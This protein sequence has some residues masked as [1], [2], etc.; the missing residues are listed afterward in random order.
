M[1]KYIYLCL[2]ALTGLTTSCKK[3]KS[4]DAVPAA[5]VGMVEDSVY[6]FAQE[7]YL[8]YDALP[9]ISVFNPTSYTGSNDITALTNEVN[10]ISQLKINPLTNKPYEYDTDPND[11]PGQAKYSFIDNGQVAQELSGSNGDFG[12][13][14]IYGVSSTD[15]RVKYVNPGSP[16]AKAGMHRG[17]LITSIVNVPGI[18]GT[19]ATNINAI[20][21]A[22]NA[23]T[24]GMTLKRNN[25]TT[26]SVTLSVANY[27][28][29]PVMKDSV[30]TTSNS[31]KVGYLVFSTFTALT[32]AQPQLDAAF[33][34]FI[35]QGV[36]DLVVDL[37]YNGG[38]VVE[39]AEY[40]DNLIVPAANT[41]TNMYTAYYNNKL[42]NDQYPLLSTKYLINKG[43][44]STAAN[45]VVF[46]KQKTLSINNVIFIVTGGTASAS[47]L[48]INNLRPHM[49]VQLLGTTTYGKPVGFFAIPIGTYQLYIPEFS[50]LNSASQGGYYT[51]M[52]PGSAD[53]PGYVAADDV[54][55]D[56]GDPT[57]GLLAH[58]LSYVS[59]GTYAIPQQQVQSVS[60]L[61]SLAAQQQS[62]NGKLNDHKFNGMVYGNKLKRRTR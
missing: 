57:E 24:I 38:G 16:A 10:A 37:R 18:D 17:D 56:F 47:E 19:S 60:G 32:N 12:F 58:A 22:L 54:S 48:T 52:V 6:L 8:W 45:T 35:A 49:N 61:N 13:F 11:P 50:T 46:S 20:N 55:K 36:T 23:T 15:L 14:P 1:K 44:F 7:D 41:G 59:V 30:Y 42:Q 39:T 51:G 29:N 28:A 33:N 3:N 25:G 40:L 5:T 2:I 9:A 4:A 53:Y 26:Y 34:Y 62:L 21:A 31:R 43:D 27:T